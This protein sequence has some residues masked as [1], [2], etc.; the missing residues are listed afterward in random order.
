MFEV[1]ETEDCSQMEDVKVNDGCEKAPEN[2]SEKISELIRRIF[3]INIIKKIKH[4][5]CGDYNTARL[6][7]PRELLCRRPFAKTLRLRL[8]NGLQFSINHDLIANFYFFEEQEQFYFIF[9]YKVE[10]LS[11]IRYYIKALKIM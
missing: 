4:L 8:Y 5:G 6:T 2:K 11:C 9:K 1:T 3:S 10:I 7:D